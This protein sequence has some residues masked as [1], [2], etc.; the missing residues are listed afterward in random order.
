MALETIS[1][2]L[3]DYVVPDFVRY[4]DRLHLTQSEVIRRALAR[5]IEADETASNYDLAMAAVIE[6]SCR[7]YSPRSGREIKPRSRRWI[8][9]VMDAHRQ[10]ADAFYAANADHTPVRHSLDTIET[11]V[12][13]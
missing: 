4:C 10:T 2:R 8:A 13:E 11:S 5:F 3:P 1:A 7:P 12:Q 6:E 9:S